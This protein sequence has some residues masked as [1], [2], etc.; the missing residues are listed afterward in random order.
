MTS[1]SE[2][3]WIKRL[4][5]LLIAVAPLH[6][7]VRRI[8][9]DS[10]LLS[11]WRDILYIFVLGIWVISLS[12][13]QYRFSLRLLIPAVLLFNLIGVAA[14]LRAPSLLI[15]LVGFRD[16][17]K[18]SLLA[19]LVYTICRKDPL[20]IPRITRWVFHV[21]ILVSLAQFVFYARRLD[22]VLRLGTI[23]PT[24]RALGSVN[25][26]RMEAFFGGAPSNLGIYIGVPLVI[27]LMLQQLG[28]R[29]P[30]WWHIG[31]LLLFA[32]MVMTLSFSAVITTGL[33]FAFFLLR[34]RGKT[35]LKIL[36][37]LALLIVFTYLNVG[38]DKAIVGDQEATNFQTYVSNIFLKALFLKN[39]PLV[40]EDAG[41]FL[42]GHGLAHVGTKTFLD[43]DSASEL[44]I[45][46][47]SDGGWLEFAVQVGVPMAL[48]MLLSIGLTSWHAFLSSRD[49]SIP[50]RVHVWGLLAALVI[51]LSSLHIVPWLRVGQDVNFWVVLGALAAVPDIALRNRLQP[52]PV[53]RNEPAACRGY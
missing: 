4:V 23:P 8:N 6:T 35:M 5:C 2:N 47:S 49:L 33:V 38:F 11:G 7:L 43:S 37:T 52:A 9:I 46:G 45:V 31:A 26:R 39:L 22:Y 10:V 42:F 17:I 13:D 29:V 32:G 36:A 3:R 14:I 34:R 27:Y 51:M 16:I 19:V 50:R 53:Q 25:I 28:Q 20:F 44:M 21:G 15:G 48:L 18:Y 40:M 24:Y 30:K 12:M 1:S 41:T